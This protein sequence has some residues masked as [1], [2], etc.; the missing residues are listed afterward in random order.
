MTY[1]NVA[2][3]P[4]HRPN[5]YFLAEGHHIGSTRYH[6]LPVTVGVF[7]GKESKRYQFI[8]VNLTPANIVQNESHL[9]KVLLVNFVFSFK[10]SY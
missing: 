8:E 7:T 5:C 10:C 2:K 4:F 6:G 3:I 1:C 9:S